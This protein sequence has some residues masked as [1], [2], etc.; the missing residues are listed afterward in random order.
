MAQ[1]KSIPA[2]RA[3]Q[4]RKDARRSPSLSLSLGRESEAR[5]S[6]PTGVISERGPAQRI[7]WPLSFDQES[8]GGVAPAGIDVSYGERSESGCAAQLGLIKITFRTPS[9]MLRERRTNRRSVGASLTD[10]KRRCAAEI[11]F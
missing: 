6:G 7:L 1:S 5:T 10:K 11:A 4:K 2:Q 9:D 8:G 3:E